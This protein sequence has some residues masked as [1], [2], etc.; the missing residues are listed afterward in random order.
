[1]TFTVRFRNNNIALKYNVT[2]F[3]YKILAALKIE[4]K[5]PAPLYILF[6]LSQEKGDFFVVK[7]SF[8]F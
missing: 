5:F 6:S 8:N 2:I 1:M 3:G 7:L 4:N